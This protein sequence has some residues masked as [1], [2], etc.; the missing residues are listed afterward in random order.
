MVDITH[1]FERCAPQYVEGGK[2]VLVEEDYKPTFS[3]LN[4]AN[5]KFRAILAAQDGIN[6]GFW[7][8]KNAKTCAP[9]TKFLYKKFERGDPVAANKKFFRANPNLIEF[10]KPLPPVR[11]FFQLQQEEAEME[12]L[13]QQEEL[14]KKREAKRQ[15]T[16]NIRKR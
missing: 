5:E 12:R 4:P 13:Q 2:K 11:D 10:A 16:A 8:F 15:Q 3:N 7:S 6:L 9:F 14:K 1:I